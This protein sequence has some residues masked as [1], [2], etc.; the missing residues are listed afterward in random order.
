MT[1]AAYRVTIGDNI[2]RSY[3]DTMDAT[4]EASAHKELYDA[5]PEG[6]TFSSDDGKGA[7]YRASLFI[8]SLNPTFP[9]EV[10]NLST[11]DTNAIQTR[12]D[13]SA[14]CLREAMARAKTGAEPIKYTSTIS[15]GE[16]SLDNAVTFR[17][18]VALAAAYGF[19]DQ[20]AYNII[21]K[22]LQTSQQPSSSR[23]FTLPTP[24]GNTF[25]DYL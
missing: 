3:I 13:I 10:S 11:T 1:S 14:A 17:A 6:F 23:Q 7:L 9:A 24:R 18:P 12:K 2:F 16:V 20:M 19:Y 8:D 21:S 4:S 15:A 5:L 22:Y 25:R